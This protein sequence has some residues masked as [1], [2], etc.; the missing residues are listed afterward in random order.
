MAPYHSV[1][2]RQCSRN[3][4]VKRVRNPDSPYCSCPRPVVAAPNLSRCQIPIQPVHTLVICEANNPAA[5]H[6]ASLLAWFDDSTGFGDPQNAIFY[7]HPLHQTLSDTVRLHWRTTL[8]RSHGRVAAWQART[9]G[10]LH[11]SCAVRGHRM[12]WLTLT[13]TQSHLE[14]P[15]SHREADR[16]LQLD[17]HQS[18]RW[19]LVDPKITQSAALDM[20]TS[21]QRSRRIALL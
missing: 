11:R 4:C 5:L 12:T 13:A 16:A 15:R 20:Q 21:T 1:P 3:Q 8:R 10:K 2:Q 14:L 6:A 18:P 17:V 7:C 19:L 9:R